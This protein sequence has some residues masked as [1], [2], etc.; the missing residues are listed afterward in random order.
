MERVRG[1][2]TSMM[3]VKT[4]KKPQSSGLFAVLQEDGGILGAVS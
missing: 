2:E 4:D 3:Q 1:K